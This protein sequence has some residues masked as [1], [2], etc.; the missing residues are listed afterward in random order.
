MYHK[1]FCRL[2]FVSATL[3]LVLGHTAARAQQTTGDPFSD[4]IQFGTP[5]AGVEPFAVIPRSNNAQPRM[6]LLAPA[7]D[8]SGRVFVNDPRGPMSAISEDG[9]SVSL[10][11][12]IRTVDPSISTNNEG[13]FQGFAFH[14]DFETNGK[15]YTL[16]GTTNTGPALTF[17]AGFVNQHQ[18]LFEWTADDP[19]ASTF[20][21]PA[22]RQVMR[23]PQRF[24]NHLGGALMFDY[25]AQPGDEDFG[26]LLVS[27]GD[28]GGSADPLGAGQ[29][30]AVPNG[31]ILRIDPLQGPQ[32]ETYTVPATNPFTDDAATLDEI[33]ALGFRN[34][35]RISYDPIGI[36]PDPIM[37]DIGQGVVEEVNRLVAEANYG[38]VEREGS[39]GFVNNFTV[40]RTPTPAA[41]TDPIAEYDHSEGQAI[42]GG[43]VIRADAPRG[44]YGGYIFG[45]LAN[46]RLFYVENV[47]TLE[48]G[49][50]DAVREL[51][52][53]NPDGSPTTMAQQVNSSR[54]DLRFGID[55]SNRIYVLNKRDGIVRRLFH[56]GCP[57]DFDGNTVVNISDLF[58]FINVF[59]AS[60]IDPRRDYDGNGV[61]NISDLF[62]F[63]GAFGE[64]CP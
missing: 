36:L 7:Y 31:K 6:N 63:I 18:I 8:G 3:A 44:L 16:H 32:G 48:N 40:A 60:G 59:T 62:A 4:P 35:Q 15:L 12:D 50:S 46:G 19:A 52:L 43:Y 20:S 13:G 17:P 34:T 54:V 33:Y 9:S 30:P 51:R 23:V 5:E 10:Y 57:A 29:D 64:V 1:C 22:P 38:W 37:T 26:L 2:G 53:V 45:D 42:T 25:N 49:G 21:G 27:F 11:L 56:A 24:N 58:A 55:E 39:F 41:F 28:G 14:P 61:E 47:G